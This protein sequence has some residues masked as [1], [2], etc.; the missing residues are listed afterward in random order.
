MFHDQNN[1]IKKI[2]KT[3][4]VI[5]VSPDEKLSAIIPHFTSSHDAGFVF[6]PR[7]EFMGVVN[8]YYALIKKSYPANTK[9]KHCMI[10][11]PRVDINFSIEKT[12]GLM[13][14]SKIHYLPVFEHNKFI[15]IISARRIIENIAHS[16]KLKVKINSVI[17]VRRPIITI[18]EDEYVSHAMA[19]FKKQRISKLVVTSQDGKVKGMLSYYDL[20][21][22]LTT[23]KERADAGTSNKIPLLQTKVRN[24]MKTNVLTL[25]PDALMSKVADLVISKGIGSVL[26]VDNGK[27][28]GI[29]TTRDLLTAYIGNRKLVPIDVVARDLSDKSRIMVNKFVEQINT[30]FIQKHIFDK[31]KVIVRENKGKK[32]FGAM[33]EM[34]KQGQKP[35][36]IKK[37]GKNL[38]KVLQDV[39]H[40]GKKA[41]K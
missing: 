23:P 30:Q 2:Y 29:I 25:G 38:E 34:F 10:H 15:G 12:A 33:L 21:S 41:A 18:H 20:I 36:V 9:A 27:P 7:D 37:E 22:F 39:G 5:K 6:G 1:M 32:L 28:V 8:P 26:V 11:P 17:D 16:D 35:K 24:F 40:K 31:A 13:M 14:A 3:E 19:L 4:N